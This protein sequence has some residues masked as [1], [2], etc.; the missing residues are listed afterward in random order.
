MMVQTRQTLPAQRTQYLSEIKMTAR[1][2]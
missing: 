1:F 2:H